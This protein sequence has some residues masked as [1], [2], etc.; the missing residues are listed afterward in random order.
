MKKVP[1][2]IVIAVA[3]QRARG[4]R[5]KR[6]LYYGRTLYTTLPRL[7]GKSLGKPFCLKRGS[8]SSKDVERERVKE[9]TKGEKGMMLPNDDGDG[10][11]DRLYL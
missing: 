3:Q 4:G 1:F 11:P 6:Q 8:S 5:A 9:H 10:R 7:L 2:S